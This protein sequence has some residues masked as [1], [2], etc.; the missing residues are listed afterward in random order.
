[1]ARTKMTAR[2]NTGG[3]AP[4]KSAAAKPPVKKAV[5]TTTESK[6]KIAAKINELDID[7]FGVADIKT[8]LKSLGEKN[9]VGAKADL[10]ER[11][12][13][14]IARL[15]G[16]EEAEEEEVDE[17]EDEA[18]AEEDVDEVEAEEEPEDEVEEEEP[19]PVKKPK[20]K[21]PVKKASGKPPAKKD[22]PVP[23]KKSAAKPPAK[24][25]KIN[26]TEVVEGVLFV[27]FDE[28]ME[29]FPCS[30]KVR[31]NGKIKVLDANEIIEIIK[32]NDGEVPEHLAEYDVA[33]PTY[34][35]DAEYIVTA[36][37]LVTLITNLADELSVSDPDFFNTLFENM[38]KYQVKRDE[39]EDEEELP[40][41]KPQKESKVVPKESKPVQE[42]KVASKEA[43]LSP[44]VTKPEV[45]EIEDEKEPQD[46]SELSIDYNPEIGGFVNSGTDVPT[47]LWDVAGANDDPDKIGAYAKVVSGNKVVSL[48]KKDTLDTNITFWHIVQG[49]DKFAFPNDKEIKAI[50]DQNKQFYEENAVSE[51]EEEEPVSKETDLVEDEDVTVEGGDDGETK[52]VV[53]LVEKEVKSLTVEAPSITEESFMKFARVVMTNNIPSSNYEVIA[54]RS[55]LPENTAK[56][57]SEKYKMLT[58]KY[59]SVITNLVAKKPAANPSSSTPK[60]KT[61]PPKPQQGGERRLLKKKEE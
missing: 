41:S 52:D 5:K 12:Q 20:G 39:K 18:E 3:M 37:V 19:E 26:W 43:K 25:S 61:A 27:D 24:G 29:S 33:A 40:P 34:S 57:I 35:D 2:K 32:E 49:K 30:H 51:N 31:H 8:H 59:P 44:K 4:K 11:L 21:P 13:N 60:P 15:L 1:M 58:T 7:S 17:V 36:G 47:Y 38:S 6:E 23:T 22:T 28:C 55:G 46:G 50:T 56:A 16:E 45:V 48:T 10:K 53:D 14:V 9:L 54:K 42:T